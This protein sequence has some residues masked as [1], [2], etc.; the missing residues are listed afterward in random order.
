MLMAAKKKSNLV[1]RYTFPLSILLVILGIASTYAGMAS[2]MLI[3]LIALVP[4]LGISYQL[5]QTKNFVLRVEEMTALGIVALVF[6]SSASL[7]AAVFQAVRLLPIYSAG[8]QPLFL[9]I[10]GA[11]VLGVA[12][13]AL[14][15][16]F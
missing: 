2:T 8:L 11:L 3:T 14:K 13:S 4:F 12:I 10:G 16:F 15:R 5:W 7:L 1:E 6:V 9:G